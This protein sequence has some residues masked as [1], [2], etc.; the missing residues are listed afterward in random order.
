MALRVIIHVLNEESVLAELDDLPNPQD[1][2]IVV[3]NPRRRDGKQLTTLANGVETLIYPWSRINFIEVLDEASSSPT[4]DS[5]V[6]F[7]REDN[8]ST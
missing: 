6:G 8:R 3:R 5:I 2:C 1:N 4:A 7:F